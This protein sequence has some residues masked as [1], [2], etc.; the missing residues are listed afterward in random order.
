MIICTTGD[1]DLV[2]VSVWMDPAKDRKM[3]HRHDIVKL[4][5]Q[6]ALGSFLCTAMADLGLP[7]L[8]PRSVRFFAA[9]SLSELFLHRAGSV[10][11]AESLATALAA[12]VF[13]RLTGFPGIIQGNAIPVDSADDIVGGFES[14]L[15]RESPQDEPVEAGNTLSDCI[16]IPRIVAIDGLENNVFHENSGRLY[17]RRDLGLDFKCG[18]S[19]LE[20][21]E[22]MQAH[23]QRSDYS[24]PDGFHSLDLEIAAE[25][26]SSIEVPNPVSVHYYADTRSPAHE[27]RLQAALSYP[28]LAEFMTQYDGC[29]NAIDAGNPL[30]P[31]L[32]ELTGLNKGQLRR[33]GKVHA[34]LPFGRIFE[35]GSEVRGVDPLGLDRARQYALGGELSLE[36]L[37]T[38]I[39]QFDAGWIPV[40]ETAW[41]CLI[42]IVAG[43]ILPLS[44]RYSIPAIELLA[45]SKG[46]WISF[47]A[48]LCAAYDCEPSQFDRQQMSMAISDIMEMTDDFS[49]SIVLP[50]VLAA[51]SETGETLPF[52]TP[53]DLELAKQLAFQLMIDRSKNPAVTVLE[54][55]R[56]WM[57]RIPALIA[58][59]ENT[60][61]NGEASDW[62]CQP[63]WPRLAT[64]FSASGGLVIQN[65]VSEQE[66]LEESSRLSHC[67]GRLYT[68]K[69]R[70]G[71]CHI[72]SV[73]NSDRSQ[74]LSTFE[75][76]P[77]VS[78]I[79]QITRSNIRIVQH[80]GRKNRKPG[81]SPCLAL[82]EWLD[83]IRSQRH[84]INLKEVRDW[85]KEIE[86]AS[87]SNQ[88]RSRSPDDMWSDLLGRNHIH[89]DV[90]ETVWQQ[91]SNH[92]LRGDLAR[93]RDSGVIFRRAG[94]RQF[95]NHLNSTAYYTLMRSTDSEK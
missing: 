90:R 7:V 79:E 31:V 17:P 51:I 70:R 39:R 32:A 30:Q 60:A 74:S 59:G 95:L 9:Q 35:F 20:Y 62:E 23:W 33:L 8:Q 27:W 75:V 12:A 34:G 66:L 76:A 41:K 82:T 94:S 4:S 78:D 11:C 93:G 52:P 42:D 29:R 1:P 44:D 24:L 37:L 63:N 88:A 16:V 38:L 85:R 77:P 47:N 54:S 22:K 83:A 5:A 92:I 36:Q 55:A 49:Y 71:D 45:A 48:Q 40:Q 61:A 86:A 68:R 87:P 15:R 43:C 57:S 53:Q 19:A 50:R 91:W 64:D 80:K 73:R 67:V 26:L 13:L 56:R 65:L 25:A 46:N 3:G 84:P 14:F 58:A 81:D 18:G 72:F 21:A 89:P 2:E 10:D 28:L 6:P 69:A